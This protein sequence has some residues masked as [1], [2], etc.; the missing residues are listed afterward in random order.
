MDGQHAAYAE[1]EQDGL[2]LQLKDWYE[3]ILCVHGHDFA[4]SSLL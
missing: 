3:P 4:D 2:K 1:L